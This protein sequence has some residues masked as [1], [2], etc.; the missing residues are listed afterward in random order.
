MALDTNG[1]PRK[2]ITPPMILDDSAS[3]DP[4]LVEDRSFGTW[5]YHRGRLDCSVDRSEARLVE[6][7]ELST[8]LYFQSR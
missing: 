1:S 7:L 5:M 6:W 8:P 4:M 2:N 3:E